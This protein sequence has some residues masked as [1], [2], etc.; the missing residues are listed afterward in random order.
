MMT[1]SE[2][3][4]LIV[5]DDQRLAEAQMRVLS[6]AGWPVRHVRCTS[7]AMA[8]MGEQDFRAIVTAGQFPDGAPWALIEAASLKIPRIPIIMTISAE[9][10]SA[11]VKTLH[12]GVSEYVAKADGFWLEL[13]EIVSRVIQAVT[14]E[15]SPHLSDKI[16]RLIAANLSDLIVVGD[17]EGRITYVS[18]A[19]EHILGYQPEEF[20]SVLGL[21]L[22]H[23]DDQKPMADLLAN[24][25]RRFHSSLTYRCR[26]KQGDFRWIESNVNVSRDPVAGTKDV[27]SISRDVSE[28]KNAE[29]ELT[30]L[31]ETLES[32]LSSAKDY[33][34]FMLDPAGVVAT[35]N[36]G[37]ERMKGYSSA[38]VIGKH[39]SIFY[40]VDAVRL[41]H[42][43]EELRIAA[44]EG[45]Y[46]EEGWRI[47]K[48]GSRFWA[49]VVITALHGPTGGLRG[50]SKVTRDAT[51][52]KK[53]A[54][55]L[56][57]ARERAE[58]ANRSKSDFLAAMSHEIRTPMNAILGMSDLLQTTE[59]DTLQQEY[60]FRFRRASESLLLLINDILD[61]SKIE[62]GRFDLEHVPFDLK[63]VVEKTVE[64]IAPSAQLKDIGLIAH[65]GPEIPVRLIG[66]GARLQQIL[67]N[68]LGNAVKFTSTGE[69]AL[70]VMAEG[71]GA[72][73]HLRFEVTD[74]GIGIP[75]EKL[76]TIFEDFI[77][78]EQY[79]TRQFGGTGLGL[80]IAR[81]L[82]NLMGGS[83]TVSSVPGKGSTFS[84]DASFA[85]D[86]NP[87][88]AELPVGSHDL[89]GKP[90]LLIDPDPMNRRVFGNIC[91]GW[92]MCP[93]EAAS[94]AEAC[95]LAQEALRNQR[96][97]SLAILDVLIP[98]G[99]FAA[100]AQIRAVCPKLPII[101]TTNSMQPRD[102]AR[103][104]E[105]GALAFAIKPVRRSE[106]SRLVTAAVAQQTESGPASRAEPPPPSP[107]PTKSES[108]SKILIAE[109]SEDNRFLVQAYLSSQR[110]ALTFAENGKDALTAFEKEP[111]DLVLM[112]IQMPVMDGLTATGLMRAYEQRSSRDRTPILALTA[113]AL[114]ADTERSRAAGCDSHLSKPISK[115][116]LIAAVE[117]FRTGNQKN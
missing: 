94:V 104:R 86:P 17:L 90:V 23:P 39:F 33:A 8:L 109:D 59:L 13:P 53:A 24:I 45:R 57:A 95:G 34:I 93:T 87:A 113:N 21:Q 7:D 28:R 112:D 75:A 80:G 74:T 9:D 81:R 116:A 107:P 26:S 72:P 71:D 78:A 60:L 29:E 42:H 15:Q 52:L 12:P 56:I 46:E 105:A 49:N 58:D 117:S 66:D 65:V 70:R 92:G 103:A 102:A 61:L 2:T 14:V 10:E 55:A 115:K 43:E 25:G 110:Y 54:D 76:A 96:P 40:P 77:Q 48:D 106:L 37:A 101:M 47:R 22:V 69:V 67:I 73:G 91:S 5:E 31:N 63:D 114:L 83:L 16:V 84:F 19:C 51:E 35:W 79:T 27:V 64:L 100:V 85:L 32:L 3:Q 50:F 82:V 108:R 99:G 97:F 44:R 11:A 89:V 6:Q 41:G 111:F 1:S 68:L 88:A 36:S 38:E 98:P 4:I 18:S 30:K 62:S 20:K